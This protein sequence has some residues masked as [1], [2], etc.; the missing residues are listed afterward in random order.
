MG[1]SVFVLAVDIDGVCADF[2][3]G[4]RPIAAEWLGVDVDDLP[5]EVSYG[6]PEWNLERTGGYEALHRFAVTERQ[7]FRNL[8][9]IEGAAATLRRLSANGIRIRIVTH[10]LYVKYIHRESVSQT[11]EWLDNHGFLYWDLCFMREK[12][13]V[14]ADLYIE[15]SPGNIAA[16]RAAKHQAIV[17]TNSTNRHLDGPRANDWR[18]AEHLVMKAYERWQRRK[19][20]SRK[21]PGTQG[22]AAP[23]TE[24]PS[25]S[26]SRDR[27]SLPTD[28]ASR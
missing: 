16:L 20:S 18:K 19:A 15:D 4:L 3:A 21:R 13:E 7:L 22:R 27:G 28:P 12:A 23:S 25:G 11:V 1:G 9:P 2:I 8:E 10:R 6:F 17:F 26:R 24:S 5:E 14:G